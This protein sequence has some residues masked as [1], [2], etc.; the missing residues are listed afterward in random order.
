MI[1]YALKNDSMCPLFIVAT[2][3][4]S[5]AQYQQSP[6]P[7]PSDTI[8]IQITITMATSWKKS[9]P[10]WY[11]WQMMKSW[12][13]AEC[14]LSEDKRLLQRILCM[15][16]THSQCRSA[17][18]N[19][20]TMDIICF[21]LPV[22]V[23]AHKPSITYSSSLVFWFLPSLHCHPMVTQP[24][25]SDTPSSLAASTQSSHTLIIL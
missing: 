9:L 7:L 25:R 17:V 2:P 6:H 19:A 18:P 10:R 4:F 13:W 8:S 23:H 5:C 20:R 3:P 1:H 11:W 24:I 21:R 22:I 16:V 12:H 14:C 15:F